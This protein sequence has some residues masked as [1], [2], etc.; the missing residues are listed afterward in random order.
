MISSFC[1]SFLALWLQL[2]C[3]EKLPQLYKW[4]P[5]GCPLQNWWGQKSKTGF[6]ETSRKKTF[7]HSDL[8]ETE[9]RSKTAALEITSCT[10][11]R[12]CCSANT[13]RE[14]HCSGQPVEANGLSP[15]G[16][17]SNTEEGHNWK[18]HKLQVLRVSAWETK[19]RTL[20]HA[21]ES[22]MYKP[23]HFFL[24][25][26]NCFRNFFWGCSDIKQTNIELRVR[27]PVC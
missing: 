16:L 11:L 4:R 1:Q 15:L 3:H 25:C 10:S 27:S 8:T 21:G 13:D 19:A 17:S 22:F 23:V 14:T 12:Q 24:S 26:P 9:V 20:S 5:Q 7:T 18:K 2:L 6:S